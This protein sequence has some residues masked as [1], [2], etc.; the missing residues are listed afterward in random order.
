VVYFHTTPE[1][2]LNLQA[3]FELETRLRDGKVA[4][5]IREIEQRAVA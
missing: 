5:Q 2:W 1:F 4:R 3:K